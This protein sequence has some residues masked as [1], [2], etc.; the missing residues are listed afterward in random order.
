[1]KKKPLAERKAD[2]ERML[3][4]PETETYSIERIANACDI[5]WTVVKKI[6]ESLGLEAPDYVE[7]VVG[8]LRPGTNPLILPKFLRFEVSLVAEIV[9]LLKDDTSRKAKRVRAAIRSMAPFL[10]T[11]RE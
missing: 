6:R 11:N 4:D 9:D 10:F 7:D 1:M 3:L 5:H 8:N 2:V